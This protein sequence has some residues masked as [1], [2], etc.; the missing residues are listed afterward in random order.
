MVVGHRKVEHSTEKTCFEGS[1]FKNKIN[2][3]FDGRYCTLVSYW[4]GGNFEIC[5]L[6][7]IR[8]NGLSSKCNKKQNTEK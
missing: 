8:Q 7:K 3:L 5:V 1:S 6:F 4:S 2:R